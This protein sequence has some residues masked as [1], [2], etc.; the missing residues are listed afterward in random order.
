MPSRSHPDGSSP[1]SRTQTRAARTTQ[2]DIPINPGAASQHALRYL[3]G[4]GPQV[5]LQAQQLIDTGRLGTLLRERYPQQH[6]VRTDKAL[7]DHVQDLKQTFMRGAEPINK[8]AYDSKIKVIQHALGTHTRISRVQGGQL[9]AKRE[10]R[11]ATVF[12]E[13]PLEFLRMIVVHELA[14]LK[15]REHDKAFYA[16][17]THMEP[18][19]HRFELDC[20]LWLTARSLGLWTAPAA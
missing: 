18:A 3:G 16:L 2:Q 11:V 20:R 19:Y 4:Y 5:L 13:A 9:K 7:Y 1:G 15:E 6:G 12:R 17:C 14:H 10:I 8:V